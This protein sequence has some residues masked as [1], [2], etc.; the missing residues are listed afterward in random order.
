MPGSH[1]SFTSLMDKI[2]RTCRNAAGDIVAIQTISVIIK[3][4]DPVNGAGMNLVDPQSIST[5][6]FLRG[7]RIT[8]HTKKQLKSGASRTI[9]TV[10]TSGR[11]DV[12]TESG[13]DVT[14]VTY[15]GVAPVNDITV[16]V[17]TLGGVLK[18]GDAV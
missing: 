6:R 11:F 14:T 1:S 5:D 10:E 4:L 7:A 13:G 9:A 17:S 18:V 2:T 15:T 12:R 8:L 16:P 3:P